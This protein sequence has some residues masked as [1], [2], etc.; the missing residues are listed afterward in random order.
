MSKKVTDIVAYITPIGWIIAF[1][2]GDREN[3]RFHLNQALAIAICEIILE[4]LDKVFDHIPLIG[5][6]GSIVVAVLAFA[7]FICWIIGLASA[8]SGT[9][10]K[11]PVLGEIKLI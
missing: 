3:S 2:A 1:L 8:I 6:I 10:K 9:E 4:I 11:V 5:W 7:V